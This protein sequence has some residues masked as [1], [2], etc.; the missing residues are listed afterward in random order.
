MPA[1]TANPFLAA[2]DIAEFI[3][4]TRGYSHNDL[5]LED[6]GVAEAVERAMRGPIHRGAELGT[7]LLRLVPH[8]CEA[9]PLPA[10]LDRWDAS[11][12]PECDRCGDDA[13]PAEHRFVLPLGASWVMVHT[14]EECRDD[15]T[16]DYG[17]EWV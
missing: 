17:V 15:L 12:M 5:A 8:H 2:V 13:E 10:A 14:C 4:W 9:I 1:P 7:P 16:F 6:P 11:W 3:G